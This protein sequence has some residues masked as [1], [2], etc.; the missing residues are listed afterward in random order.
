ML[1]RHVLT[2]LTAT[3][4]VLATAVPASA[5]GNPYSPQ[6]VCGPG[7]GVIQQHDLRGPKGRV[8][9]TAYLLWDGG[10]KRNCSVTLK[11]AKV[12]ASTW[13]ETSLARKGGK[14]QADDGFYQYYAGPLYVKAPGRC[15]IF[16]GRVSL[17]N[18]IGDS[19]ITPRF[20][21][22]GG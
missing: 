13:V 12:G 11:R 16:G 7:F 18:G 9:A 1:R 2:L 22:C 8:L 15:V 4:A 3:I 19:W 5:A 14:Y 21:H 10:S 20:G 17:G 6:G